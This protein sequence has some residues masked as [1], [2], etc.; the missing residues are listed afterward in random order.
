MDLFLTGGKLFTLN[1]VNKVLF[2]IAKLTQLVY[3]NL[4]L[5]QDYISKTYGLSIGQSLQQLQNLQ[6]LIL[7]LG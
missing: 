5:Q 1:S 4:Q 7:Y 2:A 6:T 3:L